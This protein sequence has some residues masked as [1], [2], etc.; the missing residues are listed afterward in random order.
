[1]VPRNGTS[2]TADTYESGDTGEYFLP[3]I[4]CIR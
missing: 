1:M 4:E 2:T 3:S